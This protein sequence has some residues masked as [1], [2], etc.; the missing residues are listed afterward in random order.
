MLNNSFG[1]IWRIYDI[2]KSK[3]VH[4]FHSTFLFWFYIK[5]CC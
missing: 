1:I 2:K 5:I 3:H 4:I